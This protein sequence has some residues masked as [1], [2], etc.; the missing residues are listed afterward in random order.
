[1]LKAEFVESR[2]LSFHIVIFIISPFTNLSHPLITTP[3]AP[4]G[5]PCTK[6]SGSQVIGRA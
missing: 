2:A 4:V 6:I 3:W 5:D 1:M